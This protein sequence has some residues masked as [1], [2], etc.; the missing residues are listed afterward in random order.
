MLL[1]TYFFLFIFG[2]GNIITAQTL[3]LI[4]S[5]TIYMEP[6]STRDLDITVKGFQQIGAFNFTLQF[7]TTILHIN[8]VSSQNLS[9]IY[10]NISNDAVT[11]IWSSPTGE[12]IT[13]TDG[14]SILRLGIQVSQSFP[15]IGKIKF[16]SQPIP[17]EFFSFDGTSTLS[18]NLLLGEAVFVIR[19]CTTK[20]DLGNDVYICPGD[21]LKIQPFCN[22]CSLLT[23][24][25]SSH[26]SFLQ[27]NHSGLIVT[28][29]EGPLQCY[30]SD[31]LVVFTAPVPSFS[32]PKSIIKCGAENIEI[33]PV[34]TVT[35]QYIW[36]NGSANTAI[37]TGP[38]GLYALTITNEFNCMA[39]DSVVVIQNDAPIVSLQI[40]QPSC[41]SLLGSIEITN[42]QGANIPYLYSIDLGQNLSNTG[43]FN[44]LSPNKYVISAQD[45]DDC[46]FLL[47]TVALQDVFIPQI[48]IPETVISFSLGDTL[49]LNAELQPGYPLQLVQSVEWSPTVLSNGSTVDLFHPN[50]QP[51]KSGFY[52]ITLHTVD[53][54]TVSDSVFLQRH[55]V[56]PLTI[57]IPTI[58]S[59]KSSNG[60]DRF[61]IFSS[62]ERIHQINRFAIFDRWGS[63]IFEQHGILPNDQN[64]GWDG[65]NAG[66]MTG[67]GVY[68]WV[69]EIGLVDGSKVIQNGTVTVIE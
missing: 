56:G 62:D 42:N 35:G 68:V 64:L 12:A 4:F 51:D 59:S 34:P 69:L 46:L 44:N 24:P 22:N 16:V 23:W 10:T 61:T 36:S 63:L 15:V 43:Q 2:C 19:K 32:F 7:D 6:G 53:G 67:I 26:Y 40:Q 5:D 11:A 9:D 27:V 33:M 38:P 37:T 49:I 8:S 50:V 18:V 17:T 41:K 47:D 25:D 13:L 48:N 55:E 20:L 14:S 54:C 58:I 57:Y 31:S 28:T 21:S 30:A 1:R 3:S 60:N 29:A 66:K 52:S 39:T 45:A 65:T